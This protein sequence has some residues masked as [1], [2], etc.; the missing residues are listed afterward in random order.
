MEEHSPLIK[1]QPSKTLKASATSASVAGL[2]TRIG[3]TP[4][5][6][7]KLTTGSGFG[8]PSACSNSTGTTAQPHATPN[9]MSTKIQS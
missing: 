7:S 2:V 5:T 9:K 1:Q 3:S 6:R 4:K 8:I